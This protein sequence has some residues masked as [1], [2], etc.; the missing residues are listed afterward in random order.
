MKRT[1]SQLGSVNW[2]FWCPGCE[3]HHQFRTQKGPT[4]VGPV[5]EKVPDEFT[6]SPSLLM[7]SRDP[8]S[9][10]MVVQCHLFLKNGMVK[11]LD[12]CAHDFKGK[13]VPVESPKF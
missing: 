13:T 4:E 3:I 11:F 10:K 9:G 12:D 7:R 5:W 8:I 2:W 1:L 6:F